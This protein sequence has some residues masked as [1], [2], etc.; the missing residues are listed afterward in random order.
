MYLIIAYKTTTYDVG[1]QGRRLK[2]A[3]QCGGV[4]RVM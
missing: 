2:Q 1:S 3:Q 4:N